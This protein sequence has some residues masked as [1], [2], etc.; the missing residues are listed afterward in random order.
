MIGRLRVI[1]KILKLALKASVRVWSGNMAFQ[2]G[3]KLDVR[4]TVKL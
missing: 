2:T 3:D 1:G 4:F